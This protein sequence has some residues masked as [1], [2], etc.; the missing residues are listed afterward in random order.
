M[1]TNDILDLLLFLKDKEYDFLNDKI[2]VWINF[3]DIK[4]FT[5]IFGYDM[6][7]DGE[8]NVK[9]LYD[10]IA[11]DLIEFLSGYDEED[12]EYIRNKLEEW[13]C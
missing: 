6:F 1:K 9:L 7:Y 10:C 8:V 11:F 5:N 3:S 13:S 2:I 4:D 12:I